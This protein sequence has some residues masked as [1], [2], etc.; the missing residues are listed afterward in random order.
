MTHI[1]AKACLYLSS[2]RKLA[3]SQQML[4]LSYLILSCLRSRVVEI[5]LLLFKTH[6]LSRPF[7]VT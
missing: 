2:S 4:V 6:P 3:Y 5:R 1:L 7:P